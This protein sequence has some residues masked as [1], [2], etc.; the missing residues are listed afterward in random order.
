MEKWSY[1]SNTTILDWLIIFILNV[2]CRVWTQDPEVKGPMLY[3]QSQPGAPSTQ[4]FLCLCFPCQFESTYTYFLNLIE[5][6]FFVN[7]FKCYFSPLSEDWSWGKGRS[8]VVYKNILIKLFNEKKF[9]TLLRW[10]MVAQM[11]WPC[12]LKILLAS[13]LPSQSTIFY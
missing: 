5:I 12:W 1:H 3:W 2:Q 10:V 8:E 7:I 11:V 4:L 6:S 9:E 13:F